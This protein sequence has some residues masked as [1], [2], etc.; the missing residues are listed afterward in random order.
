MLVRQMAAPDVPDVTALE[1]ECFDNPWP[2]EAFVSEVRKA[3]GV[4]L[5]AVECGEIVGY[6][7]ACI[8]LEEVHVVN[9]AVHPSRRRL[10]IGRQIL[11]ALL[12]AG[13]QRG[14]E[15]ATLEVRSRNSAA[16][17]LYE[18]FGFRA[19]A[20]RKRYYRG[21]EDDAVVMLKD[22]RAIAGWSRARCAT[23]R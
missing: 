2:Q 21:P 4:A 22:C 6:G 3:N 11:A 8:V 14:T 10:G 9:L 18:S 7:I 19:V 15:V 1:S 12:E 13:A 23:K 5:V 16:Q 17:C 20:I